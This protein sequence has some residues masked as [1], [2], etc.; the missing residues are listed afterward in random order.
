[1]R[2]LLR[3]SQLNSTKTQLPHLTLALNSRLMPYEIDKLKNET[4]MRS[5]VKITLIGLIIIAFAGAAPFLFERLII[6]LGEN[7]LHK[8]ASEGNFCTTNDCKEGIEYTLTFLETHY[9]LSSESV[10]WCM[11][12]DVVAHYE[13]PF[14][15]ALKTTLTDRLYKRCGEPRNDKP[16]PAHDSHP[17]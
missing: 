10:K 2:L 13:L 9:A 4:I 8:L 11:G 3:K 5:S 1:M 6:K 16:A 12:V 14:G 15:N 17:E 7:S